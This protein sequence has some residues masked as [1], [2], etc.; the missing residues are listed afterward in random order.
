MTGAKF[1]GP[2]KKIILVLTKVFLETFGNKDSLFS[3]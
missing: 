1:V 2:E 3:R